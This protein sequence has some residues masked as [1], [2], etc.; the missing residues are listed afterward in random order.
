M[1]GGERLDEIFGFFQP[2]ICPL[3]AELDG[4]DFLPALHQPKNLGFK[5]AWFGSSFHWR[6]CN[7]ARIGNTR[8]QRRSA[9]LTL[10][11]AG[12][13]EMVAEWTLRHGNMP[14]SQKVCTG[15]LVNGRASQQQNE[16]ARF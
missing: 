6:L 12:P 15:F 9:F 13:I 7:V 5:A 4:I 16:T 8:L 11:C 2:N 10:R 14:S 3:A 1:P